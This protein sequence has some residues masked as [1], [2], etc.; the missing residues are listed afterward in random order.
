MESSLGRLRGYERHVACLLAG[1]LAGLGL[2]AVV[3]HVIEKGWK[4]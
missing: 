1:C 4:S 3:E 2:M